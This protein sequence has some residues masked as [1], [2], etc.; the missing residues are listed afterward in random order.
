MKLKRILSFVLAAAMLLGT[1]VFSASA[2]DTYAAVGNE[3]ILTVGANYSTVYY[4]GIPWRVLTKEYSDGQEE[5]K[6]GILLL[7][8]YVM[9]NGIQYNAHYSNGAWSSANKAWASAMVMPWDDERNPHYEDNIAN[10]IKN[11]DS[12]GG[13]L[14]SDIRMYLTGIGTYETFRPFAY[15]N[16]SWPASWTTM[17]DRNGQGWRYYTRNI[18]TDT[19]PV[20]G[21]T[22]FVKGE[23]ELSDHNRT[24]NQ[25][26]LPITVA[27]WAQDTWYTLDA[28]NNP[29]LMTEWPEGAT[30][31]NAY[32]DQAGYSIAD[33]SGGFEDGVTYY[34][35]ERYFE[36]ECPK[37]IVDGVEV[38]MG[39]NLASLFK[40][41]GY[42]VP[43][44]T[45]SNQN[46]ALVDMTYVAGLS[47]SQK[48]FASDMGFSAL[49]IAAVLPTSGHGY[50]RGSGKNYGWSSSIGSTFGDRLDNDTYF[51]L[52]GEEVYLYLTQAGHTK[53]AKY[54]DGTAAGDIWTR[55]WGRADIQTVITYANNAV[56]WYKGANTWWQGLRP[57]FNLDPDA[58]LFY[59]PVEDGAFAKA[60]ESSANTYKLVLKDDSRSAFTVVPVSVENGIYTMSYSGAKTGANE[61][62]SGAVKDEEGNVIAYGKIAQAQ[63]SGTVSVDLSAYDMSDKQLYLFNEQ[64]NG[65]NET[66]YASELQE[67]DSIVL[68][69]VGYS[70]LK[71]AFAAAQDGDTVTLI[72]DIALDETATV[73]A[74]DTIVLDLN[75]NTITGTDNTSANFFVIDNYGKLT[76]K[77][78]TITL[79]AENDRGWNAAS[80]IFQN[81]GGE[82]VIESGTYIHNG[83]TAMAYVV[84]NNANSYGDA[85]IVVNG[86]ELKSSYI[87]IRNR[88]DTYGSNGGGNGEAILD[89]NG[90]TF[91]GKYSVWGQVS[92]AGVK[93]T[94]DISGGT[95]I[96]WEGNAA[97]LV[98]EDATGEIKTEIT[99]GIFS[100]DVSDYVAEGFEASL[101]ADGT[102]SVVAER[103]ITVSASDDEVEAGDEVI[104]DI[105]LNGKDLANATWILTYEADKFELQGEA[106]T[107]GV[108]EGAALLS[109]GVYDDGAVIKSYTFR[110]IAQQDVTEADFVISDT[111]AYT[112]PE[113]FDGTE[114]AAAN[115][116]KVTV[117]IE[118]IDYEV[119]LKV[120]G[121]VAPEGTVSI[122]YD[123]AEHTFVIDT[124][125]QATVEY[126]V[127]GEAVTSVSVKDYGIY[128]I[129]YTVVS[130]TGYRAV[131]GSYTLIIDKPEYV[132]EVNLERVDGADYVDGKKIVLVYT[133]TENA[134][135]KYDGK[136]MVNV[137]A[138]GYKY[139]NTT[140][141][142]YVFAYVTDAIA[143]G[144]LADYEAEIDVIYSDADL[145]TITAYDYDLNFDNKEDIRDVTTAYGVYNVHPILFTNIKYQKQLLKADIKK[146]KCVNGVD[147]AAVYGAIF[148]EE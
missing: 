114:V 124:I 106:A 126:K 90:G 119:A 10:G 72:G 140:E 111:F 36:N 8:E 147:T 120:D 102:Y 67:F 137:S 78:G 62:I 100:S 2:E 33:V 85:K 107:N 101:N 47:A 144:E 37:V 99:A 46:D 59:A 109:S 127:N 27:D 81:R 40:W 68:N 21:V 38:A 138:S 63:E 130:E 50:L 18:V 34:T 145:Y 134:F 121:E 79:T 13:Y 23:F 136:L 95:F 51:S 43:Y 55:S 112:W 71:E 88:M 75:G 93:G 146:D 6:D 108:I 11:D 132:V 30:T 70:T 61:Y 125:P 17:P 118:L 39:E 53:G 83:G 65:E 73:S 80:A 4:G 56:N 105:T 103:S 29:V 89:I 54:L 45:V 60:Q 135:F 117:K 22:Y 12:S 16:E 14:T 58:V 92:S 116:S 129:E 49:E 110:A 26:Y 104:I 66:N 24:N 57:A 35:F 122:N 113:S 9:A 98:D 19:E 32:Y 48:N 139:N 20:D 31:V 84:D 69:G 7:S 148:S 52:S 128:K 15:Y 123:N 87:A 44:L 143:D 42:A 96:A 41:V 3:D 91:E 142:R 133:N 97:V 76:V 82:L 5:A 115:N 141:Y 94:I 77:N 74:D 25:G 64:C 28:D 86:G 131:E 1:V